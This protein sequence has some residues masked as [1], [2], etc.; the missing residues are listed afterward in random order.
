MKRCPF[1]AEEIQDAAI[2]CTH[3]GREGPGAHAGGGA[4]PPPYYLRDD[5]GTPVPCDDV[6]VWR[7]YFHRAERRIAEA[8]RP[9]VRLSTVCLGDQG[10]AVVWETMV[11]GGAFDGLQE[12][13]AS[14]AA[15]L[16]G[17]RRLCWHVLAIAP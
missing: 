8:G 11:F 10:G 14:R 1:C 12:R 4:T 16:H 13:Y 17:H 3:C 5:D 2:V 15:A 9:G 7:E 6:T